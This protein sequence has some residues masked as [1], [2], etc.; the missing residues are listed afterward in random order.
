[1]RVSEKSIVP[2]NG[3]RAR[4]KRRYDNARTPLDRLCE[5]DAI[6][7]AQKEYLLALRD[8]VNPRL[9]RQ[10]IYDQI[11]HVF[12]L[13]NSVQGVAEDIYQ[14]LAQPIYI[15]KGED[16]WVTLL[17]DPITSPR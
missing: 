11:K 8:Q 6:S 10:S 12:S 13:P 1:M 16:A 17:F 15:P 7:Q 2:S 5:I 3:H 9:L 14:T 4:V